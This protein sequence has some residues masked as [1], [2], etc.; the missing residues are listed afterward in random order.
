MIIRQL[1]LRRWYQFSKGVG[2]RSSDFYTMLDRC[3][4]DRFAAIVAQELQRPAPGELRSLSSIRQYS[5]RR[6]PTLEELQNRE[7]NEQTLQWMFLLRGYL[8][9]K[10]EA[11]IERELPISPAGVDREG[12]LDL[13]T[14]DLSRGQPILVE[15]K[16]AKA[17]DS[18]TG[19]LLEVLSHWAFHVRYFHQFRQQLAQSEVVNS[20][21]SMMPT[22]AIVAPESYFIETVRRSSDR[23]RHHEVQVAAK[24]INCMR[25]L[26]DLQVRF[27][28]I[29][30]DWQQIGLD[31]VLHDWRIPAE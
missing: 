23:R 3:T 31:F 4:P 26:Y 5:R 27:L 16:R 18:L 9:F 29:Q 7:P 12:G 15:L 1:P 6:I 20:L 25:V 13:L 10:H 2:G 30:D 19:V 28:A 22:V 8:Q 21:N 17:T 11:I 14:F 24:L